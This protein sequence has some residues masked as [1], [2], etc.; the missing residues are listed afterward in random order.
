MRGGVSQWSFTCKGDYTVAISPAMLQQLKDTELEILVDFDRVCKLLGVE[1]SISSGTLLGA[2]RHQG[3]IPW[4]DDIDVS[5]RREDYDKFIA[6]GQALLRDNL[7][8]Q[9]YETDGNYPFNFGK[10][11][12]TSTV[13]IVYSTQKLNMKNGISIDIFPIDRVSSNKFVKWV[14]NIALSI[15]LAIKFSCTAEWAKTSKSRFRG[16]MR[17]LLLPLARLIGTR[18]L[19]RLETYV[20]V[21][22]NKKGNEYTYGDNYFLPPKL[23]NNIKM[24]PIALFDNYIAMDFE[25]IEFKAINNFHTYLTATY[26]DYMQLPPEE[27]QIS[28]QD[29]IELKFNV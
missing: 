14:D 28:L 27:K 5:L 9:T 17:R 10:I 2:V 8:I 19:N 20:R 16:I 23:Y 15:I 7:F 29:L 12:D 22:N 13:L 3:F 18:K 25:H 24:M 4:D 11:R 26:G 21:K 6:A 1:Y